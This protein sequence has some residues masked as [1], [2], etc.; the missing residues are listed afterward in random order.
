MVNTE[1]LFNVW[2]RFN[3]MSKNNNGDAWFSDNNAKIVVV[4]DKTG[5]I[6]YGGELIRRKHSFDPVYIVSDDLSHI[7][8]KN[9]CQ[10]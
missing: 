7:I 2:V 5:S 9:N 6:R 1:I 8:V 3:Y 10:R 4:L